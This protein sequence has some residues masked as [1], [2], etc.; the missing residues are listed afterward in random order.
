MGILSFFKQRRTA[1]F[2]ARAATEVAE[3]SYA[4]VLDRVRR[5]ATGMRTAEARGYVRS[6][7][8]DIVHRELAAIHNGRI[9]LDPAVQTSIISQATEAIVVRAL[10]ELR[11]TTK[12]AKSGGRRAA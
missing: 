12:A 8:L 5:R 6:R 1:R 3:R 4:P 7:A 2:A 9:A 11:D 10:A